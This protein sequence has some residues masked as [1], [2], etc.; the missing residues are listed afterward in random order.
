MIEWAERTA[1]EFLRSSLPRRWSHV[2]SVAA[3]A[4]RFA[5]PLGDDG[6]V[7][8]AAA[9]LHDIGY[10]PPLADTGFHPL[11]GARYLRSTDA[12]PRL[13]NLV[14]RHSFAG[15]EAEAL[16]LAGAL[17]EFPDERTMTRDL[18]W[19]CDLTTGPDGQLLNFDARMA[20]VRA[21]YAPEHYVIR[22]LD[23]A[24]PERRAAIDRAQAWINGL[25][26]A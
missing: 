6:E 21:R 3:A 23:A 14:A 2:R 1:E 11:D 8:R 10:A 25:G 9:W 16:G 19:H 15:S 26:A 22:A 13:V 4:E 18:L 24:M 5:G 12:P 17:A 20:D 7:L